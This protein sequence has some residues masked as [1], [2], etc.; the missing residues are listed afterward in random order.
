ME[1]ERDHFALLCAVAASL[2]CTPLM[3]A[4]V[5]AVLPEIG[6]S[7]NAN[8]RQL[9]LVG[10]LYTL[11][12]AIFQ[13]ATGSLGDIHG[14]KRVFISGSLIFSACSLALAFARSIPLFLGLRFVQGAAGAMMSASGLALVASIAPEGKRAAYFGLIG[15]AV[16]SGIAMGPPVAGIVASIS[17]WPS[18]FLLGSLA[19]L[20][21]FGLMKWTVHI[22]WRPAHGK[23]FDIVACLLYSC[24]MIC[25]AL[26]SIG[27]GADFFWDFLY[28][29]A[30]CGFA[31]WF[32][33]WEKERPFPLLNLALLREKPVFAFSALAALVNYASFFGLIF[34]FSFYL[35]I[36]K[37]VSVLNTGLILAIQPLVQAISTPAATFLCKKAG[38]G[39]VCAAG[40]FLCGA[41]LFIAAFIQPH[42][43][44]VWLF[45]TQFLLGVGI[46]LFSLANTTMMIESAGRDHTGQASALIGAVR[47]AGQF[48]SMVFITFSL[49]CFLGNQPVGKLV[50][51][52]FMKSMKAS[53]II[54][55][56]LNLLAIIFALVRNKKT[57]V[58]NHE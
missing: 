27:T 38:E 18:L 29:S 40:A 10:T 33:H 9:A 41:G 17:G 47:T 22:D 3:M 50:L 4:G 13:L 37:N 54:F 8:A 42:S 14:H 58:A 5:N 24:A 30:F 48:C 1:I 7:L 19:I 12:L 21:V 20:I 16:Y 49:G 34:Y 55:G 43:S 28:L 6:L 11:G 2:F 46:S 57:F 25:L 52:L 36:A 35:Q 53:L 31:A 39:R 15:A 32:F 56:L 23:K 44:L 26:A 51:P 45:I